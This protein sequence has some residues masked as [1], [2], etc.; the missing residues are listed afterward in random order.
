MQP[1]AKRFTISIAMATY[2]GARFLTE[3]LASFVAQER[4]P[5]ELVVCDDGSTDATMEILQDFAASAPFSV[6]V[7]RNDRNLGFA[8]NFEK[9][10]SLCNGDLIFL[11]DQD[12][13]WLPI[14]LARV[15]E[16]FIADSRVMVTINDMIISDAE[17][18]HN[19]VTQLG[20][21]RAGGLDER[22]FI[23]GCC[24]ALRKTAFRFIYPI[25]TE[26]F[27][28]DRWISDLFVALNARRL[29]D[30]PLQ[31]YR[32]HGSN[33]TNW[34]YND[35]R[36]VNLARVVANGAFVS[37][38]S[39]WETQLSRI[40]AMKD[41]VVSGRETLESLGLGSCSKD[42]LAFFDRQRSSYAALLQN[43]DRRGFTSRIHAVRRVA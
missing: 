21:I 13:Y 15:E 16:E 18:K 4:L 20:N 28:H 37:P 35:P 8:R 12:D 39:A 7:E 36:G 34:V 23:A 42:A 26:I 1:D 33:E 43:S 3:Q 29:I 6:R 2:N 25:P 22:T 11:S 38:I 14:K 19:S 10:I 17:L 5:D 27:A 24:I 30:S 9:A 32:R 40:D 41:R 31:L